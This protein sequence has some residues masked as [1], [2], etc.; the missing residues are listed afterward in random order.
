MN[1]KKQIKK[2]EKFNQAI[3][4]LM[5]QFCPKRNENGDKIQKPSWTQED[6]DFVRE[7]IITRMMTW[8]YSR[9]DIYPKAPVSE[10]VIA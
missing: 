3:E 5:T 2:Q 8:G 9:E 6:V 4:D 1:L 10:E 7:M